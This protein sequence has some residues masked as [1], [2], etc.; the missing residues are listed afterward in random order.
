MASSME[1]RGPAG[2][3]ELGEW[4]FLESVGYT[5]RLSA[6]ELFKI[7]VLIG[8]C[9]KEL[10]FSG[11]SPCFDC[12]Y[13]R[14]LGSLGYLGTQKVKQPNGC[15]CIEK[16]IKS[17]RQKLYSFQKYFETSLSNWPSSI[18]F[19]G[20]SRRHSSIPGSG[21]WTSTSLQAQFR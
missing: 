2:A 14:F 11:S 21:S 17:T 9:L 5:S 3:G 6:F 10:Y 12:C 8:R 20:M 4:Y 16:V 19:F 7:L 18:I 1:T 13:S 15:G